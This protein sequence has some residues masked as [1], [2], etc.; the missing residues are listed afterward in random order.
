MTDELEIALGQLGG[1][2]WPDYWQN[3]DFGE[4]QDH[5]LPGDVC[6]NQF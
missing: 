5:F 1:S 4:L 6:S 3:K 2:R